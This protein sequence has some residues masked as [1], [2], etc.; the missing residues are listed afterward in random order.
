[1]K[2]IRSLRNQLIVKVI[3]QERSDGGVILPDYKQKKEAEV[4]SVGPK[5]L[6]V[7][8]GDRVMVQPMAGVPFRF[9]GQDLVMVLDDQ[10]VGVML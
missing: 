8:P 2:K 9:E 10:I 4:I 6:D 1:M 7:K 3:L 5:V